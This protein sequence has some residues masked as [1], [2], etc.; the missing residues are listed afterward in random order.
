M[1]QEVQHKLD[2]V[3]QLM[4]ERGLEAMLLYGRPN[5]SWI[6]GGEAP[7]VDESTGRIA[8]C[9]VVTGDVAYVVA[10]KAE[11]TRLNEGSR[12]EQK[13][14]KLV[15]RPWYQG[16]PDPS[17]YGARNAV[18]AD[19]LMCGAVYLGDQVAPLRYELE[20]EEIERYRWLGSQLAKALEEVAR[21]V[22]PGMTEH[23][24]SSLLAVRLVDS[25]ITPVLTLIATDGRTIGCSQPVPT[26]SRMEQ[27]ATMAV[28]GSR[29]GLVANATRTACIGPIPG[30]VRAWH[31]AA[32]QID[33]A[34][35]AATR[36]GRPVSDV[37]HEIVKT[38]GNTD[39]PDE[40]QKH[41]LGGATG[42]LVRDYLATEA[43]KE[44]IGNNQAFAWN[45]SV[46]GMRS[47]DT[48]IATE[49]GPDIITH[50][51]N[52]PMRSIRVSD[53]TDIV[54][55]DILVR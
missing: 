50:T 29:W 5:F 16:L 8:A 12:L 25:G 23:K 2:K 6:T 4:H 52:W 31:D 27:Y 53:D 26:Y 17:E 32:T 20:P 21:C 14:F 41:H 7:S 13:G 34:A 42:Y 46:H 45:P 54:R 15:T 24:I 11:I 44:T 3:R 40:W 47:E 55:P 39:Y 37:Y 19:T 49:D 33:A 43:S 28:S 36:P 51:G 30:D 18:G 22:E 10:D 35:I 38:Y 48:I 1:E 9:A